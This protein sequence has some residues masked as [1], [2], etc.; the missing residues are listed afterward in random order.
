ML[1]NERFYLEDILDSCNQIMKYTTGMSLEE[2]SQDRKTFDAVVRNVEIIG[3]ASKNLSSEFRNQFPAIEWRK[4][5]G[6][7]DFIAHV[8][9]GID[10]AILWDV[11]ENKIP[12]LRTDIIQILL[13]FEE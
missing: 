4:I 10:K 6:M 7:R 1:R 2:F 11:V 3:E 8:Y 9:F 13:Q 5:T 12:Q